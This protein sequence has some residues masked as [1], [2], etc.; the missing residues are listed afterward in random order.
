MAHPM[1]LLEEEK[2]AGKVKQ[3]VHGR[4]DQNCSRQRFPKSDGN[5]LV[6]ALPQGNSLKILADT[7]SNKGQRNVIYKIHAGDGVGIDQ[8]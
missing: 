3:K 8:A 5:D 4:S 6:S 7:K 2:R 1:A